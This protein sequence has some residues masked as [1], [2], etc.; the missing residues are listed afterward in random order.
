MMAE[1]AQK[2]GIIVRDQ[3]HW[4]IG[5]RI[6]ETPPLRAP[7]RST[8]TERPAL[9]V[10]FRESRTNRLLSYFPWSTLQV[11]KMNLH[12]VAGSG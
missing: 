3:T 11:L 7:T 8:A 12:Y 10:S 4:D 5:F 9:R 1:A 2:Y 6:Q